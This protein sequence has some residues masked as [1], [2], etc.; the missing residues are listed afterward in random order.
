MTALLLAAQL[1]SAQPCLTVQPSPAF[2]CVE[3]GWLPPNHPGIPKVAPPPEPQ[4]ADAPFERKFRVGRR[5]VRDSTD[6]FITGAGQLAN[7]TSVFFA[8][9]LQIGD[10]C[11]GV[12]YIRLILTNATSHD[13]T[14]LP[15][16]G[17]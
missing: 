15:P 10:G 1:A 3:G 9:C 12:G 4:P 7:G 13:F 8:E 6:I 17:V 14:E 16:P 2:T 5:Y 11:F